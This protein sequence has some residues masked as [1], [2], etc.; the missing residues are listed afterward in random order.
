MFLSLFFTVRFLSLP[1]LFT[2]IRF[3]KAAIEERF[4]HVNSETYILS[5]NS[6]PDL[7]TF[8]TRRNFSEVI[9]SLECTD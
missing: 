4:Y 8:M 2:V 7:S 9:F 6:T 5:K 1:E 3:N